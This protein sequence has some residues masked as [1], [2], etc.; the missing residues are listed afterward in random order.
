VQLRFSPGQP[1]QL[2]EPPEIPGGN[3]LQ[4]QVREF[5]PI[6]GLDSQICCRQE[7][8]NW[9]GKSPGSTVHIAAR[10][11]GF[12]PAWRAGY[13]SYYYQQ[14]FYSTVWMKPTSFK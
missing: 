13:L 6:D 7:L 11:P 9:I 1:S 2:G 14:I 10:A 8:L 4:Q 12:T 3:F 5:S